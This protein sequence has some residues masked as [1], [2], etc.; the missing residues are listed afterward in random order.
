MND[1]VFGTS[2]L[3]GKFT[4]HE[5]EEQFA[6]LHE[7]LELLISAG[8]FR[9]KIH[10][11]S[12][13]DKIVG[14][15]CWCISLCAEAVDVDLLYS[16]NSSIGQKIALT[17]N[18]VKVLPKFKCPHSIEPH[19]IQGLDCIRIFPVI[20]WLVKEAIEAKKKYGDETLRFSTYQF[21]SAGWSLDVREDGRPLAPPRSTARPK[22]QFART[23][24]TNTRNIEDDVRCTLLEYGLDASDVVVRAHLVDDE[25][26]GRHKKK[27][28]EAQFLEN[29]QASISHSFLST[30]P[31]AE[32]LKSELR[33]I[34][35]QTNKKVS[36]RA[37]TEMI[38]ASKLSEIAAHSEGL[39]ET[40]GQEEELKRIRAENAELESRL[41]ATGDEEREKRTEV[42][43][44]ERQLGELRSK[45]DANDEFMR[46]V[47]P[48][49]LQETRELLEEC[50]QIRADESAYK[51]E[52]RA[53]I[54]ELE[55]EVARLESADSSVP[56]AH[57]SAS[58]EH[59]DA[60]RKQL[61]DVNQQIF[62]LSRQIDSKPTQI[63]LN[64]YQRRFV[65]LYN[66]GTFAPLLSDHSFL[67]AKHLE[68]RR[69]CTHHNTLVDICEF[70]RKEIKLLDNIDEQK[71]LAISKSY[72]ESF[73][74]NLE[75]VV[76]NVTESL[77]RLSKRKQAVQQKRDEALSG[78]QQLKEQQRQYH[79]AIADFQE[80][81]QINEEL[82]AE[83]E[84]AG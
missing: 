64:Q 69:L 16:E 72:N 42:D 79:R 19:Q 26:P 9:A 4:I 74:K 49:F 34:E 32:K 58:A 1:E 81:C 46:S 54:G 83:E 51:R 78:V 52:C 84:A 40:V 38:D 31:I 63:E 61:G 48:E 36:A 24:Q 30:T 45:L 39:K 21:A 3:D 25:E 47:D 2:S 29:L 50:K 5:D 56:P 23:D 12:A 33:D 44:A 82:L 59:L 43:E 67:T 80:E 22:R 41:K 13:F 53:K 76:Q 55:A 37:V 27:E 6:K 62:H 18:I 71:H 28:L 11:L 8:Y 15:M 70:I 20:Q 77:N 17:E 57:S 66:Q 75:E 73:L 14:G 35:P 65:E 10:G 68:A 60:L 7:I